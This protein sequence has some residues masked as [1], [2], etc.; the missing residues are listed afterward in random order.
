MHST[1]GLRDDGHTWETLEDCEYHRSNTYLTEEHVEIS[2]N[3]KL[4]LKM[5]LQSER[6]FVAVVLFI[7]GNQGKQHRSDTT[8]DK[9]ICSL[10]NALSSILPRNN[11]KESSLLTIWQIVCIQIQNI[12]PVLV[13][14]TSTIF[15]TNFQLPPFLDYPERLKLVRP[16]SRYIRQPLYSSNLPKGTVDGLV[17]N[18]E[19]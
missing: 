3:R 13:S 18:N 19:W 12:I 7:E 2:T 11:S 10:C 15:S 5:L 4:S 14:Q 6:I 9:G 16:C 8:I 17:V 1:C